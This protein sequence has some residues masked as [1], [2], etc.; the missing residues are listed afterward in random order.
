MFTERHTCCVSHTVIHLW[1]Q[2]S[3][4]S[5]SHTPHVHMFQASQQYLGLLSTLLKASYNRDYCMLSP[6]TWT[7]TS[8][9]VQHCKCCI[10]PEYLE[11]SFGHDDRRLTVSVYKWS[12]EWFQALFL[13]IAIDL[14]VWR[15]AYRG[16]WS[17]NPVVLGFMLNHTLS[18]W[19]SSAPVPGTWTDLDTG[20]LLIKWVKLR[21][22]WKETSVLIWLV[23]FMKRRQTHR[24]SGTHGPK[25]R[26]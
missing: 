3:A 1:G 7:T 5:I 26:Y 19:K 25:G 10:L 4:M 2:T 11:C 24:R 21:A 17:L 14:G 16:S 15:R 12:K 8:Y 20:L 23:T 22:F 6:L 18:T 9:S 13:N